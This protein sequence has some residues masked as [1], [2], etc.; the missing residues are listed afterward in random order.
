MNFQRKINNQIIDRKNGTYNN[1]HQEFNNEY[2]K[3]TIQV[4]I[5]YIAN[6]ILLII[7]SKNSQNLL[8][9]NFK[10]VI[11]RVWMDVLND[12]FANYVYYEAW[13][14][15][16]R[17]HKNEMITVIAVFVKQGV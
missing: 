15:C 5:S 7:A 16:L 1:F 10:K 4:C 2:K 17:H 3:Y 9:G 11:K 12:R 13:R 14:W 6:K 8:V